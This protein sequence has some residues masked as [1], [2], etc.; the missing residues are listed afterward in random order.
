MQTVRQPGRPRQ[1][2]GHRQTSRRY[3]GL[4]SVAVRPG[5]DSEPGAEDTEADL[6]LTGRGSEPGAAVAAPLVPPVPAVPPPEPV[7]GSA[8]AAARACC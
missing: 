7:P 3:L 4:S 8:G 5:A 6:T 2:D 1:R